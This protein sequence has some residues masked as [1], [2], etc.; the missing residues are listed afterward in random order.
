MFKHEQVKD[1]FWL[2]LKVIWKL[3]IN[4]LIYNLLSKVNLLIYFYWTIIVWAM[5]WEL[6]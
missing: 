2:K 3:T 1:K 5:E 4:L 6:N